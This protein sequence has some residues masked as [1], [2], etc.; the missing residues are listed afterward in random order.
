MIPNGR[1]ESFHTFDESRLLEHTV[2]DNCFLARSDQD[3]YQIELTGP[4]GK[5]L[6]VSAP[7]SDWPYFQIFTPPHRESIAIE[8]MT[9]NID[10]LNNG[11]GLRVLG[12]YRTWGSRFSVWYL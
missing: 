7:K 10:A 8:P 3:Q 1:F 5:R 6:F 4:D 11:E 2:L 9:C 12:P